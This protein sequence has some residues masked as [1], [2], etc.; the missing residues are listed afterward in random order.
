[1]CGDDGDEVVQRRARHRCDDQSRIWKR[2]RD[3]L[4]SGRLLGEDVAGLDASGSAGPLTVV[5]LFQT[6]LLFLELSAG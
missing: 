4:R 3:A 6:V 5:R 1:M 2:R